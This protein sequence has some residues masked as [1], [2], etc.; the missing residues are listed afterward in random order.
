MGIAFW[1]GKSRGTSHSFKIAEEIH[2]NIIIFNYNDGN[3]QLLKHSKQME[4][5]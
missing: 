1:D 5:W 3:I 4:D 2:K